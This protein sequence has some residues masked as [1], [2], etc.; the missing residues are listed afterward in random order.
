MEYKY[1]IWILYEC[2]T[3]STEN[4]NNIKCLVNGDKYIEYISSEI[5]AVKDNLFNFANSILII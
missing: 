2:K 5:Y 1:E 3:Y 4:T